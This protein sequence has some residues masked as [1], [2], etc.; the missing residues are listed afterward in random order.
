VKFF[1]WLALH[2]RLWT[3]E[4]WMRH[5]L[6]PDSD[7]ALCNQDDESFNHLLA[8]CVYTREVWHHLLAHVG[9]QHLC[10]SS[11]SSLVD[12]WLQTQTLVPNAFRRGFDSLVLLV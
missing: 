2:G 3:A 4:R 10:P 5:G 9:F 12:W 11:N 8:S 7:C 6:Q 1:F